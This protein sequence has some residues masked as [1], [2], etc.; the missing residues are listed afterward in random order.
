MMEIFSEIYGKY[1]RIMSRLLKNGTQTAAQMHDTIHK[2]GFGETELYFEPSIRE[3]SWPLFRKNSS[4]DYEPIVKTGQ[5]LPPTLLEKAW[6]KAVLEDEK[7]KLF[8]SPDEIVAAKEKLSDVAPLFNGNNIINFDQFDIGDDYESHTIQR[9]FSLLLEA[10]NRKKAVRLNY[11]SARGK[12]IDGLFIPCKFEYSPKNDRFRLLAVEL[13]NDCYKG[14]S[15]LNLGRIQNIELIDME[16]QEDYQQYFLSKRNKGEKIIDI[17]LYDERNAMERFMVE[18]SNYQKE[19]VYDKERDILK[20]KLYIDGLDA[21]EVL[22]K[23]LGFGPV[24]KVLGPS[25]FVELIKERLRKQ[26]SL[27]Q[28]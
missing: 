6:L 14:Y 3:E 19:A 26:Q 16:L 20:V 28:N 2:S 27:S 13:D 8:L 22:I 25:D 7:A 15:V 4:G 24:L 9:H 18:F 1:Y 23:L 10:M 5:T 17:E 12:E 21:T 11:L